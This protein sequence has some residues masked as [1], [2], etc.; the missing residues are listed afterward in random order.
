[1]SSVGYIRFLTDLPALKK[2]FV[3]LGPK[4]WQN[5]IDGHEGKHAA[6]VEKAWPIFID[7]YFNTSEGIP[8]KAAREYLEAW[9]AKRVPAWVQ[10]M[11]L[12][13]DIKRAAKG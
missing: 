11:A 10:D 8:A 7:E 4:G 1:M 6:L 12:L 2:A 3:E 9:K 13:R 5:L